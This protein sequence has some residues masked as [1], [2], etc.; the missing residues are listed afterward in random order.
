M[1]NTETLV[2]QQAQVARLIIL[3][4][5]AFLP[6]SPVYPSSRAC[7]HGLPNHQTIKH[8]AFAE[9]WS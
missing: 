1:V 3:L 7:A 2:H 5:S 8:Y 4:C 6:N 9:A